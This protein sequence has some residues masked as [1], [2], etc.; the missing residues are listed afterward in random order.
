MR[1]ALLRRDIISIYK[2]E[3]TKDAYGSE[4]ET[5]IPLYENVRA[6]GR[7][8]SENR[9]E[10]SNEVIYTNSYTFEIRRNYQIGLNEK[11]RIKYND[12]YYWIN[13]I[14]KSVDDNNIIIQAN[15]VNL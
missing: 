13:S 15:K 6:H 5:Y 11:C 14:E 4:I 9:N 7:D 2:L 12:N 1:A 10:G 8:Y 3:I